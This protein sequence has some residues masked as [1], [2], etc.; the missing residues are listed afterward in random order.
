ME[1]KVAEHS[2]NDTASARTFALAPE[3][4]LANERKERSSVKSVTALWP[5]DLAGRILVLAFLS[6]PLLFAILTVFDRGQSM[7]MR[8]PSYVL[9]AWLLVIGLLLAIPRRMR[10]SPPRLLNAGLALAGVG[11]IVIGIASTRADL[12]TFALLDLVG[13]LLGIVGLVLAGST[14]LGALTKQL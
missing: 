5:S 8:F 6:L 14:A 4:S 1:A 10:A 13:I 7:T 11:L 9:G 3:V 12:A 2:T